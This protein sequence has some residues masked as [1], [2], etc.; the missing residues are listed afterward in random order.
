M[1][2][3][4]T[5]TRI[6]LFALAVFVVCLIVV[7]IRDFRIGDEEKKVVVGAVLTG[8]RADKGWNESHYY[9]ILSA[10]TEL[11]CTFVARERIPEEG[12]SLKNAVKE[13]SDDGCSIIFL[14][15]YG[16]GLYLDELSAAFPHIAF[17]SI[18]GD[19]N[20]DNCTTYF[21]RMYQVRYLAGIVAGAS[22][23]TGILGFVAAMPV[24]EVNRAINAYCL[25][26]RRSDPDARVL[27]CFTGS[28]EDERAEKLAAEQLLSAGADVITYHADKPYVIE[29]AEERGAFSTGYESVFQE[30]SERFLTAAVVNWDVL[31]VKVLGDFLSGRANFSKKYWLGLQDGVVSLYPY[32]PLVDSETKALVESDFWRI[33][34]WRDVFSGEIYDNRGNL[35]CESGESIS[36][37]ELFLGME[38]YVDGVEIYGQK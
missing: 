27:V 37:D 7:F 23:K 19:E 14:T 32:S 11:G 31:Y 35:R 20:S 17:Y 6:L 12:Q 15:S 38:W 29:K 9:G 13:L 16:Y 3:R 34:T 26:A 4:E 18:S 10:C 28:W 24:S 30:Y 36:D 21:A 33:Q 22:S 25:G 2:N 5:F 8:E 1:K